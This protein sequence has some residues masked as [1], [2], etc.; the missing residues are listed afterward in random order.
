MDSIIQSIDDDLESW[1]ILNIVD[2]YK[3]QLTWDYL[4]ANYEHIERVKLNTLFKNKFTKLC[5]DL[6]LKLDSWI[7]TNSF[8]TLQKVNNA[9]TTTNDPVATPMK[10]NNRR[11]STTGNGTGKKRGKSWRYPAQTD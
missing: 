10:R 5:E 9:F 8:K 6:Q 11:N 3:A 2:T 4:E 7:K 1:Q